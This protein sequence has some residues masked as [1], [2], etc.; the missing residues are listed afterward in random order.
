MAKIEMYPSGQFAGTVEEVGAA[1]ESGNIALRSN[2]SPYTVT[3]FEDGL[4]FDGYPIN[5]ILFGT[6]YTGQ[7]EALIRAG[8]TIPAAAL[9]LPVTAKPDPAAG[10]SLQKYLLYGAGAYLL[11]KILK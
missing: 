1:L 9:S 3:S 6:W 11:L 7:Q 8:W 4:L 5:V 2:G 10:G